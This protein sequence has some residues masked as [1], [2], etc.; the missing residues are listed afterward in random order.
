MTIRKSTIQQMKEIELKWKG[1]PEA[2]RGSLVWF[3]RKSDRIKYRILKAKLAGDE[4][5]INVLSEE[6]RGFEAAK[7]I[8]TEG[9]VK[10]QV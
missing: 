9:E 7:K 10:G 6:P 8:F 5:N 3:E 1:K 2:L 4:T